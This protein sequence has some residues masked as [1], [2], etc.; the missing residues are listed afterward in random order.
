MA[1]AKT[2]SKNPRGHPPHKPTDAMR[3]LVRDHAIVGTPQE[4]ICAILG[5]SLPTLHKHY[6]HELDT[7]RDTANAAIGGALYTKA[8]SGDTAS[9]IFWLKTRARWRETL[10]L[11][12]EDGSLRREPIVQH[13]TAYLSRKHDAKADPKTG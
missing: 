9:M 4:N 13:V 11:S 5:I 1:K 3:K 7:S 2:A 6:R 8:M 12:N 10:D